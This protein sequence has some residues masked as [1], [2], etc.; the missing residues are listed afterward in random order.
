MQESYGRK[1]FKALLF[2]RFELYSNPKYVDDFY[3][4]ISADRTALNVSMTQITS[5]PVDYWL[6]VGIS[7]RQ[8]AAKKYRSIVSFNV[9]VCNLLRNELN[10]QSLIHIWMNN[11]LK[12]SNMPR[13][14][15]WKAKL[16]YLYYRNI[17]YTY[18][19]H[20]FESVN[21]Y[22]TDNSE[23]IQIKLA[24][25]QNIT[26]EIWLDF[27]VSMKPLNA[28]KFQKVFSFNLNGCGLLKRSSGPGG[29]DIVKRW[30]SNLL[31]SGSTPLSFPVLKNNYSWTI[32]PSKK[33]GVH[34]LQMEGLYRMT[35]NM[36]L[37]RGKRTE[38]LLNTSTVSELLY[39]YK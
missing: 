35:C 33:Y 8:R 30:A 5:V 23:S 7:F 32:Y 10:Q 11:L 3:G 4:N 22:T 34:I 28:V 25:A 20:Y 24:V 29:F 9:N 39:E 13:S 26:K 15:P 6:G 12:Y 27:L 14:C 21:M 31:N 19:P 2:R 18:N 1:R 16:R 37:K 38:K 36:Y 17:T